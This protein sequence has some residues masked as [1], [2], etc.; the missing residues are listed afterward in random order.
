MAK[1]EKFTLN[2]QKM[3]MLQRMAMGYGIHQKIFL[4]ES[5]LQTLYILTVYL[6]RL[7]LNK[8]ILFVSYSVDKWYIFNDAKVRPVYQ[9]A[10]KKEAILR[11]GGVCERQL[12]QQLSNH[13]F[14]PYHHIQLSR[15][16]PHLK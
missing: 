2:A 10:V 13:L 4:N 9:L 1:C 7:Q 8:L 5:W 3:E 11:E 15:R 6:K 16:I 14:P 12:Y